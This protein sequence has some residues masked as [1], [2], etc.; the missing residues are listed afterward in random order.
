LLLFVSFHPF[1]PLHHIASHRIPPAL[2]LSSI[3]MAKPKVTYW[4]FGGRADPIRLAFFIGGIDFDDNR[5]PMAD[6][7][8]LKPTT[9]F[10]SVP[11]LEVDG[12]TYGQSNAQLR[13]AGKLA[14]LYPTDNVQGLSSVIG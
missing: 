14:S 7:P 2:L 12:H 13:Y 11:T 3:S 6:W 4:P 10:G 9:P 5:V 8:A 1:I